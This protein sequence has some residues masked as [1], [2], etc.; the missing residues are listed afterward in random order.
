[1]I[2]YKSTNRINGK[3]YIGQTTKTLHERQYKHLHETNQT[4]RRRTYFHRAIAKYGFEN[5]EFEEIDHANSIEELN[6]KEQYWISYYNSTNKDIGYNLDSGGKNCLKADS[7]KQLMSEHQK[8]L[9]ADPEIAQRM[10]SGLVKATEAWQ[11]IARQN[12]VEKICPTCGKTFILAPHEAKKRKYCSQQCASGKDYQK[13]IEA[14]NAA[15]A[16]RIEE[17]RNDMKS[18][19]LQWCRQNRELVYRCPRNKVTTVYRPLITYISNKYPVKDVRVIFYSVTGN[20]SRKEFAQY[21][22]DYLETV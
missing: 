11:E 15:A 3:I 5:F 10:R 8:E 16:R 14:A 18:D 19:I 22:D 7:T 2:I 1:M 20:Y 21:I 6:Q 4:S 9:W 13:G 17:R 12:R